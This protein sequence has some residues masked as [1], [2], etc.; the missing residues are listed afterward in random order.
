MDGV[1]VV[2]KPVGITSHDVVDEVRAIF[3]MRKVGHTGT[4]DPPASGVLPL[5]LG[6]ATKISRFLMDLDKEYVATVRF[7]VETTT[8]DSTG[9]VV[10]ERDASGLTE[11]ALRA[12]LPRFQGH[13]EQIP[14]MVSA[15]RKDGVRLYELARQGVEVPREPRR[16]FVKELELL[17]FSPPTARLRVVCSKGT[18]VRTLCADIGKALGVGAHQSALVRTRCGAFRLEDAWQLER[19]RVLDDKSR[20]VLSISEALAHIPALVVAPGFE[21]KVLVGETIFRSALLS[22]PQHERELDLVRLVDSG[23]RLLSV[24]RVQRAGTGGRV[25]ALKPEKVF[26]EAA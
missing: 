20:A 11:E 22:I 21:R 2:D 24:A 23:G 17:E 19:L 3:R 26:S 10:A 1:L 25:V 4:L 12:V 9:E 15:I 8:Q 13:I 16:V 7:G 14:P 5:C 18:Y 6:R